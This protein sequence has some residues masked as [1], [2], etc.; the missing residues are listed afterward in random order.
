MMYVYFIGQESKPFY[1]SIY[2]TTLRTI[3]CLYVFLPVE[4][5]GHEL[6]Y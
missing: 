5:T 1:L 6:A 3:L 2:F 4:Q